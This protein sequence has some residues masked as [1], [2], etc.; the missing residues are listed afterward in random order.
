MAPAR[1]WERAPEPADDDTDDDAAA[2]APAPNYALFAAFRAAAERGRADAT[3]GG[4]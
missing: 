4:R 3:G 1:V 2:P